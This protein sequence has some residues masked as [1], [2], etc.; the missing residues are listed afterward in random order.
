METESGWQ[1]PSEEDGVA[2]I[3]VCWELLRVDGPSQ[4]YYVQPTRQYSQETQWVKSAIEK[5][6]GAA[7]NLKFLGWDECRPDEGGIRI[8]IADGAPASYARKTARTPY[9]Q[10][11][12]SGKPLVQIEA[13]IVLNFNLFM[14]RCGSSD[15]RANCITST[16][17]HMFGHALGITHWGIPTFCHDEKGELGGWKQPTSDLASV[18]NDCEP[19]PDSAGLL[20]KTDIQTIQF[21]YGPKTMD[22]PFRVLISD[23]LEKGQLWENIA[24]ILYRGSNNFFQFLGLDRFTGTQTHSW[25]FATSGQV[26]Y[27]LKS[28]TMLVNEQAL[29]GYGQG[30]FDLTEAGIY[31]LHLAFT[32]SDANGGFIHLSLEAEPSDQLEPRPTVRREN[33]PTQGLVPHS[34][35]KPVFAS[36]ANTIDSLMLTLN[37]EDEETKAILSGLSIYTAQLTKNWSTDSRALLSD[38]YLTSLALDRDLLKRALEG[39][40]RSRQ[41]TIYGTTPTVIATASGRLGLNSS[42][43]EFRAASKPMS[44]LGDDA[45]AVL[46]EVNEDLRI[47]ALHA[48]KNP[49][50]WDALIDVSVNSKKGEAVV[51]GF[52]VWYVERGWANVQ[53]RWKRFPQVSSPAK[54]MLAPGNYMMRLA[55]IDLKTKER[56]F[57]GLIPQTMGGDGKNL[58]IVDLLVQ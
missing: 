14:P 54:D 34:E 45:K 3:P 47:K 9:E 7:A 57:Q 1:W 26:C 27:Q 23:S 19:R 46:R 29:M 20:S 39:K 32:R 4:S 12:K 31:Q 17:I 40:G 28:Y 10:K 58:R 33:P 42:F 11:L 50:S 38:I 5:S 25:N 49:G 24:V 44:K 41:P 36:L 16:A 43:S 56:I 48:S 35:F 21:L 52:E 18:M 55:S 37:Q 51:N 30:C 8:S 22:A 53:E 13:H 15:R 6:W 2:Q